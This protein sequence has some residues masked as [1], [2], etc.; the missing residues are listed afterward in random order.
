MPYV[1]DDRGFL[2]EIDDVLDAYEGVAVAADDQVLVHS[3]LGLHN[4]AVDT[5]TNELRGVF[6]YDSASGSNQTLG[7]RQ[8]TSQ[9]GGLQTCTGRLGKDRRP[10]HSRRSI[11]TA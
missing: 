6:D 4:I 5:E 8:A 3:D 1:I 11:A 2:A 10:R 7:T 9:K